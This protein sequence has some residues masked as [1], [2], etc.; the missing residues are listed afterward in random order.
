MLFVRL[1]IIGVGFLFPIP[2][3]FLIRILIEGYIQP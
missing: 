2:L 3:V 1:L